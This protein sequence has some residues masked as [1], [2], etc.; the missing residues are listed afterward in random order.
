MVLDGK[1]NSRGHGLEGQPF[2]VHSG[3]EH[4]PC[5]KILS[6][7]EF[8]RKRLIIL[9]KENFLKCLNDIYLCVCM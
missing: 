6:K 4:H 1:R 8:K 9:V 2:A 7:V 3:K 5:P